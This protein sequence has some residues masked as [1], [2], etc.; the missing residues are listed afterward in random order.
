M[1]LILRPRGRGNWS[2]VTC[3]L[4]GEWIYPIH[5]SVGQVIH[6]GGREWRISKVM[7]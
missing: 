6:M 2:P 5:Y 7:P 3:R 1:T 4:E